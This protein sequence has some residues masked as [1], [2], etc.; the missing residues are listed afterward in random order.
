MKMNLVEEISETD[1]KIDTLKNFIINYQQKE[2]KPEIEA[3]NEEEKSAEDA[4]TPV[5]LD[6][7]APA[8]APVSSPGGT[9]PPETSSLPNQSPVE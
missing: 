7:S 3:I 2:V 6:S 9:S 5:V 4:S 8:P 1:R